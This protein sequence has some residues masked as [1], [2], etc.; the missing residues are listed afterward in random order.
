MQH[1]HN[2]AEF[3]TWLVKAVLFS[4][5]DAHANSKSVTFD[6]TWHGNTPTPTKHTNTNTPYTHLK[7][8]SKTSQ[9]KDT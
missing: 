4:L 2:T 9:A 3:Q 1:S 7:D 6:W 5:N 8:I